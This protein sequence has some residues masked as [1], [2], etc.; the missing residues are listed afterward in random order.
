VKRS[1][2]LPMKASPLSVTTSTT[3][4]NFFLGKFKER[5]NSTS[6]A[7]GIHTDAPK[8]L[9]EARK[10]V[11]TPP[12]EEEGSLSGASSIHSPEIPEKDKGLK[13][14][15]KVLNIVGGRKASINRDRSADSNRSGGSSSKKVAFASENSKEK[16]KT[17]SA[18]GMTPPTAVSNPLESMRNFG[19]NLDL[20]PM[21]RIAG[22]GSF[23]GFGRSTPTT[24]TTQKDT[25]PGDGGVSELTT[26][27]P[28]LT[29]SLPPKEVAK[30]APPIKKF[31][32]L[33]NPG[34]LKISEVME[35]LRDYRRLAG[36]LKDRGIV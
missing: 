7:H 1:S 3:A 2:S 31:M 28:D 23:R 5:Q 33:Q 20:N 4:T 21:S 19:K 14:E 29:E 10:L 11:G 6:S 24:P 16:D 25:I 22:M 26:A 32:D 17:V 35:L 36:A 8:T 13:P 9:D 15:D 12:P 30:V 34:D 27:F 18:L